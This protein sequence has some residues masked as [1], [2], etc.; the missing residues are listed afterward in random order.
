MCS[1]R[2]IDLVGM[3]NK[4]AVVLATTLQ[5]RNIQMSIE[6]GYQILVMSRIISAKIL[7]MRIPR[8]YPRS[9]ASTT[10]VKDQEYECGLMLQI[11]R[12]TYDKS[13]ICETVIWEGDNL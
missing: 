4:F 12:F 2:I 10:S 7:K 9:N 6:G 5:Q 3:D 13:G 8:L 1:Q 11:H